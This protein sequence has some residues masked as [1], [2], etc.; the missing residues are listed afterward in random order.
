METIQLRNQITECQ[1]RNKNN[2]RENLDKLQNT[3]LDLENKL[4]MQ[5]IFFID[6]KRN[7]EE[8]K[9][10]NKSLRINLADRT[11]RNNKLQSQMNDI[12]TALGRVSLN[13]NKK[14]KEIC[15]KLQKFSYNISQIKPFF[16]TAMNNF[17][18]FMTNKINI[19]SKMFNK[20]LQIKDNLMENLKKDIT[21]ESN[22]KKK[23]ME[24]LMEERERLSELSVGYEQLHNA[25]ESEKKIN[26]QKFSDSETV[27]KY[28]NQIQKLQQQITSLEAD[29]SILEFNRIQFESGHKNLLNEKNSLTQ[30]IFNLKLQLAQTSSPKGQ[31]QKEVLQSSDIGGENAHEKLEILRNDL[32]A[33]YNRHKTTFNEIASQVENLRNQQ[34]H[35]IESLEQSYKEIINVLKEKLENEGKGDFDKKCKELEEQ[36]EKMKSFYEEQIGILEDELNQIIFQNTL[37]QEKTQRT[38][39]AKN[40]ELEKVNTELKEHERSLNENNIAIDNL[41]TENS[42]LHGQ[43]KSIQFQLDLRINQLNPKPVNISE[44]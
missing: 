32:E 21:E 26:Q 23:L 34:N 3:I 40:K 30:E 41:K 13:S 4:K 1:T 20:K 19:L 36:K 24:Q 9:S 35:E 22:Q 29:K 5:N 7:I 11:E 2:Q 27:K 18:S 10:E 39:N 8:F 38:L 42:N 43:I 37:E 14:K 28:S 25:F 31:N 44:V 17:I 6:L 16:D 15:Q 33:L 12:K